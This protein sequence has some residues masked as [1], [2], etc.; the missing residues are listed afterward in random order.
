MAWNTFKKPTWICYFI[1]EWFHIGIY[2]PS[3]ITIRKHLYAYRYIICIRTIACMRIDNSKTIMTL[4]QCNQV[5]L[6]LMNLSIATYI[7]DINKRC[8]YLIYL[9][10]KYSFSNNVHFYILCI[11]THYIGH[12]T[13]LT[14][15]LN[16][17][18]K[19][20]KKRSNTNKK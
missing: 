3:M 8:M 10:L 2:Y 9:Y 1:Y 6:R 7:S 12:H 14:I 18:R 17:K 16:N 15:L 20:K 11:L 4:Y 13:Q 5:K 19:E